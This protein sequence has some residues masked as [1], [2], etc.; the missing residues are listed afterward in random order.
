MAETQTAVRGPAAGY[1]SDPRPLGTYAGLAAA[2]NAG[3]A[4]VMVAGRH[5]LPDR[6]DAGD[7][8]LMGATSHKLSRLISKDRVTSFARAPFVRYEGDGG[9]AEVDETPRGTGVRRAVGE[10][11]GC[12]Y[13]L[14]QWVA[15]A[16]AGGLLFAPRPTRF[17]GSIFAALTVSDFLQVAYKAAQNRV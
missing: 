3:L 17:V 1:S 7:V 11:L 13:C 12:P 6:L 4:G 15:A 8:V 2:F 14:G 9:P 5:R 16:Y 10:L